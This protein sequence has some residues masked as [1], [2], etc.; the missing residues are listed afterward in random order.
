MD[1]LIAELDTIRSALG[2]LNITS[3]RRNLDILLGSM[4]ALD[5]VISALQNSATAEKGD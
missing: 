5:R 1:D 4:Q 3:S 2:T